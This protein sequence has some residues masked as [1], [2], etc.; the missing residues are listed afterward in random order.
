MEKRLNHAKEQAADKSNGFRSTGFF[1]EG[2]NWDV[3]KKL[4]LANSLDK[5]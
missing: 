3:S 5:L 4:K 2:S 1:C